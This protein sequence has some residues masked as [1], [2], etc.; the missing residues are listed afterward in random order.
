MDTFRK[1]D[2]VYK[3]RWSHYAKNDPRISGLPDHTNFNRQEGEEVLYLISTLTDHVAWGVEGF[4]GKVEKLIHDHLPEDITSQREV[5][6]WI[7]EHWKSH[8][9]TAPLLQD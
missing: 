2:L 8:Q 4:G 1:A 9:C 6:R 5:M 7:K 3:Y